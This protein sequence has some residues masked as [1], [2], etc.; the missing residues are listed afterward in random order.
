M[1]E[2]EVI[3]GPELEELIA[4][5]MQGERL[6]VIEA[7][8]RSQLVVPSGGEIGPNFEGFVPVLFDRDGTPMLAVFTSLERTTPVTKLAKY[9]ITMTGRDLVIR[10]PGGHGIVLNPGH[11]VGLEILPEAIETILARLREGA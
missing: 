3:P 6:D 7:M 2:H 5:A 1:A 10:M 9:A 8:L 11:D 4:R